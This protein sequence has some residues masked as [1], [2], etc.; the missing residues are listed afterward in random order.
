LFQATHQHLEVLDGTACNEIRIE[1]YQGSG[2]K[3]LSPVFRVNE[4]GNVFSL[5]LA[6]ASGEPFV[7]FNNALPKLKDVQGFVLC[8]NV[9]SA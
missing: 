7:I 1:L 8:N 9:V 4:V 2:P 6:E 3:F 5:D